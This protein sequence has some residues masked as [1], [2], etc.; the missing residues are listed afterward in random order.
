MLNFLWKLFIVG[1]PPKCKHNFDTWE[2][3]K[4]MESSYGHVVVFQ[5]RKCTNCGFT[6]INKTQQ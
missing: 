5:Q 6:E 3:F 4:S 2:V 1:F